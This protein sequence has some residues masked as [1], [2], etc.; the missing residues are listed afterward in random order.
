MDKVKS[1]ESDLIE[2]VGIEVSDDTAEFD[3]LANRLKHGMYQ[4]VIVL[5]EDHEANDKLP[6]ISCC[7]QPYSKKDV[8]RFDCS[9]LDYKKSPRLYLHVSGDKGELHLKKADNYIGSIQISM[10]CFNRILSE[11]NYE[12]VPDGEYPLYYVEKDGYVISVKIVYELPR[13]DD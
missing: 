1:K 4:K 13:K 12:C 7:I 9:A 8:K 11:N 3:N 10:K 2:F 6:S 5:T